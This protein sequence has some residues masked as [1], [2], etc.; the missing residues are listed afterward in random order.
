MRVHSKGGWSLAGGQRVGGKM[1]SRKMSIMRVVHM[2][3]TLEKVKLE[4]KLH[5]DR[6]GQD[7]GP[8]TITGWRERDV[9]AT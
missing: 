4:G 7:C 8:I 9:H 2:A 3:V 6:M 1:G 5:V